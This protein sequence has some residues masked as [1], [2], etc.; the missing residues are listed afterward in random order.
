MFG[1]SPFINYNRT[2]SFDGGCEIESRVLYSGISRRGRSN[3]EIKIIFL[4]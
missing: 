4:E 1:F 2:Q 3:L